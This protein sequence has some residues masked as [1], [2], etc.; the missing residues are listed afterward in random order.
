M[1]KVLPQIIP[2]AFN[3]EANFGDVIQL[4][5]HVAKGDLPLT[6]KWLFN[7]EEILSHFGIQTTKF[8]DR[9]NFLTIPSVTAINIGIYTCLA[10]NEAGFTN[11]SAALNVNGK[12]RIIHTYLY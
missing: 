1:W 7:E 4:S 2:F 9:S 8:G 10:V 3:G 5:C 6:I 11:F 12:L